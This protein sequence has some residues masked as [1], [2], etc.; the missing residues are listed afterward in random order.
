MCSERNL[1]PPRAQS[2]R[3]YL[4]AR[5]STRCEANLQRRGPPGNHSVEGLDPNLR[6]PGQGPRGGVM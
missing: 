6:E 3:G 2:N 4:T 5:D 1:A